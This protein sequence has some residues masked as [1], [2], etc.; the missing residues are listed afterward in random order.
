MGKGYM[1]EAVL[2]VMD[3]AFNNIALDKM[4]LAYALGNDRSRGI[5]EKTLGRFIGT[6]P[7]KFFGSQYSESELLDCGRFTGV[8]VAKG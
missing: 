6:K 5:K 1:T 3:Y 4:I 2:P 7:F 8:D